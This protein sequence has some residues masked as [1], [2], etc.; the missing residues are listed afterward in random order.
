MRKIYLG[1]DPGKQGAI[2]AC[3]DGRYEVTL[4]PPTP[5]G[6]LHV[7]YK[8]YKLSGRKIAILE[9]AQTLPNQGIKS[10]GTYLQ[11]YGNIEAFCI[12]LKFTTYE[13]RP[14]HWQKQLPGLVPAKKMAKGMKRKIIKDNSIALAEK[15]YPGINVGRKDG[16]ADA[17]HICGYGVR[18]Y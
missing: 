4:M 8:Y 15:H 16:L 1:I 17:L 12:A 3:I 14:N 5:L 10:A 13:I 18:N 7:F 2:A 6:I 11:H 9:K